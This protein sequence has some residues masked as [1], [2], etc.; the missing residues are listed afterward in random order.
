MLA[1]TTAA[2]GDFTASLRHLTMV[3]RVPVARMGPHPIFEVARLAHAQKVNITPALRPWL[4]RLRQH[5]A[6][7]D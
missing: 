1:L 3:P 2:L 4:S 7:G 6:A 5:V